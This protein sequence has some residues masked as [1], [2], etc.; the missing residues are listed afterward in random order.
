MVALLAAGSSV[1]ALRDDGG[2]GLD[3]GVR[4]DFAAERERL[5]GGRPART[6]DRAPPDRPGH[7]RARPPGR[8]MEP[9]A[10]DPVLG[11]GHDL[12]RTLADSGD[13]LDPRLFG[14]LRVPPGES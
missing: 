1:T 5:D 8:A 10:D 3:P 9:S 13:P 7:R 6:P 4:P 2:P 11:G 14:T 12:Q